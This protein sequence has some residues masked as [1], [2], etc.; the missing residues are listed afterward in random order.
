MMTQAFQVPDQADWGRFYG[1][2][3]TRTGL[4]LALYKP[5]QLQ[6]RIVAL[7]EA[8]Q[9]RNL[10]DFW[11]M[12]VERPDSVQAFSDRLAI[13][14]TE[15]Y[16]DPARW[17][18]LKRVLRSLVSR[19]TNL[20]CWSAG[21]SYGAETYT[22][23]ILLDVHFRGEHS[24]LGSDIDLAALQSARRGQFSSAAIKSIPTEVR[25]AYFS[26]VS[27]G[28]FLV[29]DSLSKYVRFEEHNL[30]R[31]DY[32]TGFDL[33]LCRNVFIYLTDAAKADL[34]QKFHAA[35]RPGGVLFTGSAERIYDYAEYGF[36]SNLPFFYTKSLP[37]AVAA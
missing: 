12:I 22:L 30:L 11:E 31:D 16:R 20:K 7:A 6:R 19:R 35:L 4:D 28:S 5:E 8:D 23:A 36:S 3:R 13:N 9:A 37:K 27:D 17:E 14:V 26:P 21:C 25:R 33:I 29:K 15:F 32:E 2:M 1:N 10:D 24:I 18:E 34:L